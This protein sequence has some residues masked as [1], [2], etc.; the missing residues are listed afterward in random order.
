MTVLD[1]NF[2]LCL[3]LTVPKYIY[4]K[5]LERTDAITNQVLEPVT[6]VL[7]YSTVGLLYLFRTLTNMYGSHG[8]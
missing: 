3:E 7:T 8:C 5:V 4:F 1:G 2:A 6:F